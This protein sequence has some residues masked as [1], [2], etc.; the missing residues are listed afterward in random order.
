MRV[1]TPLRT[2]T[3]ALALLG[4]LALAAAP[5]LA[6][7]PQARQQPRQAQARPQTLAAPSVTVSQAPQALELAVGRSLIV[8]SDQDIRRISLASPNTADVLL[9]S[10]RQ[11]Y[12][13]GKAPGA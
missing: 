5:A 10:P 11:V 2:A 13:T 8:N 12:L 7:L 9:L 3:A 4:I 1:T 6:Q